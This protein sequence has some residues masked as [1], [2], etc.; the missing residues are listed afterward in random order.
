MNRNKPVILLVELSDVLRMDIAK[1]LQTDVPTHTVIPVGD[2][3]KASKLLDRCLGQQQR[4]LVVTEARP[5]D[6][7]GSH[8]PAEDQYGSATT[9]IGKALDAD[10]SV[11]VFTEPPYEVEGGVTDLIAVVYKPNYDAVRDEVHRLI[12]PVPR[13]LAP[14][15]TAE[16]AKRAL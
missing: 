3:F 13:A 9:F 6:L 2:F 4:P 5:H 8:T 16:P 1:R 15:A 10:V 7:Q 12:R 11:I 14:A